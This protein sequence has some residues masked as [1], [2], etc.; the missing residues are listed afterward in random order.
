MTRIVFLSTASKIQDMLE[1]G[2]EGSGKDTFGEARK[3]F[4]QVG[5]SAF[6]LVSVFAI[7]I[8]AVSF[9]IAAIKLGG[10]SRSRMEGKDRMVRGFIAA[11]AVFGVLAIIDFIGYVVQSSLVI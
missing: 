7:A 4:A 6:H 1:H 5:A 9:L 3:S 8:I 2:Y 10:D 11:A